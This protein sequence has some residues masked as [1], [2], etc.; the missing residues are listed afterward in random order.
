MAFAIQSLA[1]ESKAALV[2]VHGLAEY[3]ARYQPAAVEL[4]KRGI[5][6]FAFDLTGHGPD[7]NPRTH[8]DSFDVFVDEASE[9]CAQAASLQPEVPLFVWGHSMGAIIALHF[10]VRRERSLAGLIVSSNSLEVFKKSLNPL[11]PFFLFA[12]RV[13]PRARIPLGLDSKKMSR[14]E[15]VQRAH[16]ND[17][18]IVPTA[19]LKLIVEFAKA[20]ESARA[21]A[22]QIEQPVLIVH[23]EADEVAPA[24]GAQVLFDA[25]GPI[26][27]KVKVFPHLRHEVHNERPADRAAFFELL[28]DW[29]LARVERKGASSSVLSS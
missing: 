22:S 2:I 16:A 26:D 8:V 15:A 10:A 9:A 18:L 21:D 1:A 25:L 3:G 23:G 4:A 24:S 11:H 14:D 19:S 7:A 28:C 13:I 27:K 29:I 6:T 17:P 20:C 5:S 12:S